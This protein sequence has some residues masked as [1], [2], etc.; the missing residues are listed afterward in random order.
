M[1]KL[2]V[3][4]RSFVN[5]QTNGLKTHSRPPKFQALIWAKITYHLTIC[6]VK[7]NRHG[8]DCLKKGFNSESS[9]LKYHDE[10]QP[11]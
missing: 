1:L 11:L 8:V 3:P 5:A 6:L 2:P 9:D 4:F 10:V 7:T